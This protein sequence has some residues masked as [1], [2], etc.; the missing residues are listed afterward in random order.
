MVHLK[1]II[2]LDF[3]N[4]LIVAQLCFKIKLLTKFVRVFNV[5]N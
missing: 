5:L 3:Y 2:Y 4:V 1:F